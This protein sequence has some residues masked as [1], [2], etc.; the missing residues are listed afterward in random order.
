MAKTEAPKEQIASA[1]PVI[2]SS[3][4]LSTDRMD[5]L[6]Q[7]VVLP[8]MNAIGTGSISTAQNLFTT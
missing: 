6:N 2:S 8:L 3:A 1:K 5:Q 4:Q 7:A